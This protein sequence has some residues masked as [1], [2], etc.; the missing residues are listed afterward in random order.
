M[1]R[2]NNR[3]NYRQLRIR[4]GLAFALIGLLIFILGVNPGLFG[5]DRSPVI[6]FVQIAVFLFGLGLI[7]LG[8]YITLNT[9]WNGKQKSILADIGFRLVSTGFV[10][11]VA[12]GMADIFGLGNHPF[13]EVPVFGPWQAAGVIIGEVIIAAGFL[14]LIPWPDRSN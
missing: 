4:I 8:G 14:M 5:L 10:F 7:S 2:K 6:G 3:R 1:N 13:P 11:A 12:A 9:L